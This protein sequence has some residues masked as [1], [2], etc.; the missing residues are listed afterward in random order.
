MQL[1]AREVLNRHIDPELI[2]RDLKMGFAEYFSQA[3][4]TL[5]PGLHAFKARLAAFSVEATAFHPLM[6]MQYYLTWIEGLDVDRLVDHVV[7]FDVAAIR[8]LAASAQSDRSTPG[9]VS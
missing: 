2:M 1:M 8:G 7:Q 6:F 3:I 4:Q 9:T 5:E